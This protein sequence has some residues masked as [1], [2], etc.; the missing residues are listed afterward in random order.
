MKDE[1][2]LPALSGRS[3]TRKR[4]PAIDERAKEILL[5]SIA[6]GLTL[7]DA[8]EAAGIS[9]RRRVLELRHADPAFASAYESAWETGTDVMRA[10]AKRR[11]VDGVEEAIVS[12]GKILGSQKVYSDRLLERLL[13]S[14]DPNWRNNPPSVHIGIG[15]DSRA[16]AQTGVSFEDVAAVLAKAGALKRFGVEAIEAPADTAE[17]IGETDE[18]V[19][20]GGSK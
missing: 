5:A 19:V 8:V 4:Y 12:A 7:K 11:A 16:T 18:P 20:G 2:H 3:P 15:P 9:D 13:A 6:S 17:V 1:K 14:R 10:E